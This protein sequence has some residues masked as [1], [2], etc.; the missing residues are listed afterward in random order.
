MNEIERLTREIAVRMN[1][2]SA[3]HGSP[4][5]RPEERT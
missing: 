1:E 2:Q 3:P 5:G 4:T